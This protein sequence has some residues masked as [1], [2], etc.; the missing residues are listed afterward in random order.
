MTIDQR[1]EALREQMKEKGLDAYIIPS[2][3]PHQSEYVADHWKSREWISGFTGSA[4]DVVVTH[5]HAGL[6]TDSRYFLQA[7]EELVKSEVALHKLVTQGRAEF[8]DWLTQQLSEGAT[9]GCDGQLFAISQINGIQKTLSKYGMHLNTEHDLINL[10]WQDRP[11]L[12]ATPLFEHEVSFSGKSRKE[13]LQMIREKMEGQFADFHLVTTLDDIAWIY[14]IRGNDVE[15]SPVSIAYTVIGKEK[16]WLFIDEEKVGQPLANRFAEN[17]IELMPYERITA[18]L[19]GLPEVKRILIDMGSIN[20]HLY[21]AIPQSAMISGK[22]ISRYLKAV[23]NEIEVNNIKKAMLKDAVALTRLYRWLDKELESRTVSEVEL[24]AQLASFRKAQGGYH[25]ESFNAIVGYKGNG[26]IVHYHAHPETCAQIERD[27]ILLLDSG[28]QY[29]EGTTDI[30]RTTA[31]GKPTE[32]QKRNFTLVL[33]GHIALGTAV[34]PEKTKGVQLDAFARQYLW[35]HR[36]DYGHGTGHGVGAFLNVHE[37]PQGFITGLSSRGATPFEVGMFTS[38]EPGFYKIGE[39]GI[40]IENLVLTVPDA[41]T[42]FGK[43]LTFDSLTL[44]PIDLNLVDESLLNEEE[45]DWLNTYHREVYE[46][47][48]PLLNEEEQAWLKEMCREI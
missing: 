29:D 48:S 4:G 3:D 28:G 6:W 13:K 27:G 10:I 30:T 8:I 21:D 18:F 15:F 45:K 22:T 1:I 42:E 41:E 20:Y 44:F 16:A 33:K 37:P 40:R 19:N 47:V 35:K 24:A 46:K 23:K 12:P 38:N 25:G 36:L 7:E 17:Q 32:E 34:F 11:A 14:N 5:D 39:Y 43:F 2:S 26:A 9:V 31:M